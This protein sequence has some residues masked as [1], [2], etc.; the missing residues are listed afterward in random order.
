[1]KRIIF[2]S[3]L[4]LMSVI[5][6]SQ[7]PVSKGDAQVNA[8]VGFSNWG[9]PVYAGFDY[10][11]YPDI[12]AG[13]EVSYRSKTEDYQSGKYIYEYK[14]TIWGFSGNG[15][16]HIGNL[17]KL[18]EKFDLYAGINIG[19]NSWQTSGTY[20]YAGSHSSGL[21]VGGQVGGRYYFNSRFGANLE[22]GGSNAFSGGKIGISIRLN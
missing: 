2:C 10:C 4:I 20:T 7:S 5:V 18:P 15:N 16:Y 13:I 3:V 17:L 22:F 11:V 14:H 8:G 9:L 1:M 19:F 6:F 21:G 12:T